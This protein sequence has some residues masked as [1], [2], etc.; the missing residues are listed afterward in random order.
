MKRGLQETGEKPRH[1]PL[2]EYP[3][4][5]GKTEYP[6]Q[7]SYLTLAFPTRTLCSGSRDCAGWVTSTAWRTASSQR[8]RPTGCPQLGYKDI[9]MRDM[10]ALDI[11]TESCWPYEMEKHPEPTPQNRGKEADERCSRQ[12]GVKEGV[13]QLEQINNHVQM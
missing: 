11:V 10:K 13:Q 7:R 2:E 1:L 8:K 3:P 9:C 12:A 6:T 5:P 4:Y